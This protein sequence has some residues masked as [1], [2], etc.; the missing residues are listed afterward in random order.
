MPT[1]YLGVP[2]IVNYLK[3][4]N[5]AIL[6]DKCRDRIEGWMS[7]T[8]SFSGMVELI[9]TVM[10]SSVQYWIQSLMFP[11]TIIMA[12]ESIFANFLWR[13][14]MHA[15]AWEQICKTKHEGCLAIRRLIDISIAAAMKLAW[16]TSITMTPFG[17]NG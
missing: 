1:R 3:A 13:K 16:R 14:K 2:L 15:W 11:A 9:K 5:Y 7:S 6:I 4:K 12:L 17:M 8:L 10:I